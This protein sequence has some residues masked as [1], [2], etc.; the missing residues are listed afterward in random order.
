MGRKLVLSGP[1]WL[2][3]PQGP[4]MG[5]AGNAFSPERLGMIMNPSHDESAR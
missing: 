4:L 5:G 2:F 3:T 1:R